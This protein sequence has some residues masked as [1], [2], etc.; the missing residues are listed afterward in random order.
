MSDTKVARLDGVLT[1][2]ITASSGVD[3]A[4]VVSFDGLMMAAALPDSLDEDRV[5]AMTAALLS[6][7]EQ[8][9][10]GFGCGQLDQLFAEGDEGFVV[11]LAAR[12][13]AVLTAV[14]DR[15]AKVGFIL[16]E[17]RR[18]AEKIADIL[19]SQ[20]TAPRP[21]L[22]AVADGARA[23]GMPNATPLPSRPLFTSASRPLPTVEPHQAVLHGAAPAHTPAH[24]PAHA[25]AP[26]HAQAPA[27]AAPAMAAPPTTWR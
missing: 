17:M 14:A 6:L 8:A 23:G 15:N 19:E 4:A 2:L 27:Q 18:A 21:D 1:E 26:A 12:D 24:A 7:G 5:A 25:A 3:A 16:Y 13:E 10:D 22:A 9:I 20:A 11:M